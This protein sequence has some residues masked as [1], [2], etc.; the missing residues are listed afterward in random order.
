MSKYII[1]VGEGYIRHGLERTLAIRINEHE[2]HWMDTRIPV[3]PYT[4]PSLDEAYAEGYE[5]GMQLSID[6]AKLKELYKRGLADAW[7]AAKKID[8]MS[9]E[10]IKNVF[11]CGFSTVF[12][13]IGASE[14]ITRIKEYEQKKQ[15]QEIKVGDEIQFKTNHKIKVCVLKVENENFDGFTIAHPNSA[16]IGHVWAVRDLT[17]WERTGRH[18]DEIAS[19][20]EKMKEGQ[21]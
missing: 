19:A 10:D 9:D 6:D 17:D 3:T 18:F 2:D 5:E 20:L 21:E 16:N 15:E 7:D 8:H 12:E 4:E 14:A 11:G 1:D 13:T